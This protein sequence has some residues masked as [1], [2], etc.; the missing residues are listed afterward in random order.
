MHPNKNR[1]NNSS[2]Y[3]R[4]DFLKAGLSAGAFASVIPFLPGNESAR[5]SPP[6]SPD[7]PSF[8]LDE[9]AIA[10]L[11]EGMQSGKY[12][13]RSIAEQY[14]DRIQAVDKEGPSLNSV[15]DMNPDALAIAD[16]LD[17]ERREK[18]ARGPMHGIPVLIKDNIDTADRMATTA[19]SM[20]LVGS[21]PPGDAFLV[22]QLRRAGAV[23]L[24][25]TNLSEWANI[26]SSHSTSG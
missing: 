16:G 12:T 10:E 22:Q 17:K 6:A 7:V 11:G 18:G 1:S 4:R 9:V 23:I 8:E 20:A 25:K 13:A 24:G 19:G 21:K 14:L 5:T 15:I 2:G 26:R 3:N